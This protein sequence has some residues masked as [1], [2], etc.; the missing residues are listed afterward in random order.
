MYGTE[1]GVQICMKK[2]QDSIPFIYSFV[3]VVLYFLLF[4]IWFY[5]D[6]FN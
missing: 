6:L 2:V 3:I 5:F 4:H 1:E